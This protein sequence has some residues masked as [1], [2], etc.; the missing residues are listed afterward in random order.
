MKS[1]IEYISNCRF[2]D[3]VDETNHPY[4]DQ[5]RSNKNLFFEVDLATI[6]EASGNIHVCILVLSIRYV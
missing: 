3:H 6:S 2:Q 1:D 4:L 5:S